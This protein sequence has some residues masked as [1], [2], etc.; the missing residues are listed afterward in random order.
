MNMEGWHHPFFHKAYPLL[1][2]IVDDTSYSFV[3]LVVIS[4]IVT[5][6]ISAALVES[7]VGVLEVRGWDW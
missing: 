1:P 2:L 5:S 6:S 3:Q 4:V 7:G